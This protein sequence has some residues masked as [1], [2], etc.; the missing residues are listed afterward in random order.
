MAKKIKITQANINVKTG[1]IQV[2]KPQAKKR[3]IKKKRTNKRIFLNFI[4]L[5][6]LTSIILLA[7]GGL[8]VLGE[9]LGFITLYVGPSIANMS[10]LDT[11]LIIILCIFGP[12]IFTSLY[13]LYK[14]KIV[15]VR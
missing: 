15:E 1:S 3:P 8:I 13:L 4:T 12:G 9:Q 6:G 5:I 2:T 7:L 14:F 10:P 11:W